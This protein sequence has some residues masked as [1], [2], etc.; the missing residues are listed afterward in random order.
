M[1]DFGVGFLC[2]TPADLLTPEGENYVIIKAKGVINNCDDFSAP[3][4]PA[5]GTLEEYVDDT[6]WPM[7]YATPDIG[8]HSLALFPGSSRYVHVSYFG[9]PQK[10]GPN[11]E[12]MHTGV[13]FINDDEL[14]NLLAENRTYLTPNDEFF[15]VH[16]RTERI[17]DGGNQYVK[18]CYTQQNADQPPAK[19][20][21]CH[22]DVLEYEI[23]TPLSLAGI[24]YTENLEESSETCACALNNVEQASCDAFDKLAASSE[25]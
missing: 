12:E 24:I 25:P 21:I 19:L 23:G 3:K 6:L 14:P 11:H 1:D 2:E 9:T 15:F 22:K 4:L 20:F 13:V 10:V 16:G 7:D 18:D 8:R 5:L 17:L